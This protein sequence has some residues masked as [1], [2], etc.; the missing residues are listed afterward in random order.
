MGDVPRI[1]LESVAYKVTAL[2][3]ELYI[4]LALEVGIE[5][6]NPLLNRQIPYHLAT[7]VFSGFQRW[8]RTTT[9]R[10]KVLCPTIRQSGNLG[11]E[12]GIEPTKL[13]L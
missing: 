10:F 12:V 1:E 8:A 2:T 13:S 6:T 3:T 5:P 11:A 4:N 9:T 7:L